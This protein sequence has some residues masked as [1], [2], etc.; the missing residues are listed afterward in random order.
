MKRIKRKKTFGDL[1]SEAKRLV[2][3]FALY[4]AKQAGREKPNLEY[5]NDLLKQCVDVNKSPR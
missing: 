2:I 5:I 1:M 4:N 3:S